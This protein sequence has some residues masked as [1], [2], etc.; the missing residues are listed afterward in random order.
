MSRAE[1]AQALKQ[2][3]ASAPRSGVGRGYPVEIRERAAAFVER[4]RREGASEGAIGREL[5]ISPMT[6]R[7]W[8]ARRSSSGFVLATVDAARPTPLGV[9]VHGPRGIRIE[10][11]DLDGVAA[12]LER[13]S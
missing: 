1:T 3:L 6:F 12:L 8:V 4:R 5:G 13:L 10:G 7:R 11:L 9:V 2:A